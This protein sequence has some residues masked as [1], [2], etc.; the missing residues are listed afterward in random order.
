MPT[1]QKMITR[2][3]I[4]CDNR[5]GLVR[6]FHGSNGMKGFIRS[7]LVHNFIMKNITSIRYCTF[8][9]G[10]KQNSLLL[11][12]VRKLPFPKRSRFNPSTNSKTKVRRVQH[13]FSCSSHSIQIIRPHPNCSISSREKKKILFNLCRKDM[14][15]LRTS[16]SIRK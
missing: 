15:E 6:E 9:L 7:V 2:T 16:T 13:F 5:E 3:L 11:V 10:R 12:E 1:L 4:P 8:S 14:K